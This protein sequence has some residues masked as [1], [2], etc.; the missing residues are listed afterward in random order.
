MFDE[1]FTL[2]LEFFK[3]ELDFL[4][5]SLELG[6]QLSKEERGH[7]GKKSI[8]MTAFLKSSHRLRSMSL[9]SGYTLSHKG[10]LK[11]KVSPENPK[12]FPAQELWLDA[13]PDADFNI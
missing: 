7:M 9:I 13:F 10:K 3:S 2:E 1:A 8:S 4:V 5:K 11:I 6:F 12:V